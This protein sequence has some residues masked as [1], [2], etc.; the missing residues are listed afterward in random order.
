MKQ[1][2]E[3]AYEDY[4]NGMKYK[5]IAEKYEVSLSAVK[6]WSTRNNWKEKLQPNSKKVATKNKRLQPEIDDIESLNESDLTDNQKLFCIEFIKCF[7]ATK[8][9]QRVYS[10]SY[11][12]AMSNASKLLTNTKVKAEIQRL[13]LAKLNRVMLSE[14]DIFQKMMD[15]AFSDITDYSDF[16]NK[17]IIVKSSKE[18]D[19]TLIAEIRQDDKGIKIKLLDKMQAL[20]W[21]GDRL[22]LL[23]TESGMKL[24]IELAKL[25]R[26]NLT[27]EDTTHDNNLIETLNAISEGEFDEKQTI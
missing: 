14:D 18:I 7:N 24:D 16:D 15:I 8:A 17:G 3:L 23:P 13:K 19:G 11:N 6:S 9:Y 22:D 4:K 20:K 2:H 1:K 5:E 12:S 27:A 26:D 10:C 25:E 21:L